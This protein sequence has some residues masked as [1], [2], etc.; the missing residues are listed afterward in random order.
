VG[1]GKTEILFSSVVTT[2]TY[3]YSGKQDVLGFGGVQVNL[4][5]DAMTSGHTASFAIRGYPASEDAPGYSIPI[6]TGETL[7]SGDIAQYIVGDCYDWVDVG[8]KNT[9]SNKSGRVTVSITK[10]RRQ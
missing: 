6:L 3:V 5:L 10:K 1:A 7:G 4:D 2:N 8:V 9:T